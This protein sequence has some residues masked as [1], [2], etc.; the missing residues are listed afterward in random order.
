MRRATLTEILIFASEVAP[1]ATGGDAA[2]RSA[3]RRQK[4]AK[5]NRERRGCLA[6]R[7]AFS[8]SIFDLPRAALRS[9]TLQGS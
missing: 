3:D 4:I 2:E 6:M 1:G 7:E 9:Q 5:N 8:V